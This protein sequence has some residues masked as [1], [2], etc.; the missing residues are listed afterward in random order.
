M[1]SSDLSVNVFTDADLGAVYINESYPKLSDFCIVLIDL[2]LI[3]IYTLPFLIIKN[4]VPG[5][6][7]RKIYSSFGDS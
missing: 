6:F 5:S 3:S 4:N 1:C 2:P 7:C